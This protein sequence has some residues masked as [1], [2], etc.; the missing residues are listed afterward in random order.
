MLEGAKRALHIDLPASS[1]AIMRR[2]RPYRGENNG[3]GEDV[4]GELDLTP[5]IRE[6]PGPLP[7]GLVAPYRAVCLSLSYAWMKSWL[8]CGLWHS[9]QAERF[10]VVSGFLSAVKTRYSHSPLRRASG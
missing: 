6:Q 3:P 5:G 2:A 4:G 1:Y 10:L 7:T 8:A 9:K